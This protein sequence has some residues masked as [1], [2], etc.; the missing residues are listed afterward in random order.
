[1]RMRKKY[2]NNSSNK[3]SKEN[4]AK[5]VELWYTSIDATGKK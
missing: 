4:R 3:K 5:F 2:P 1:M